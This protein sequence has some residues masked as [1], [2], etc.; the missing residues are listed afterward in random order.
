MKAFLKRFTFAFK[1][2]G[3]LFKE[4][5][6][7]RFHLLAAV[8]VVLLGLFFKLQSWEWAIIIM[9]IALVIGAEAMNSALENL[10]DKVSKEHSEL[11]GKAKDLAAASVLIFAISSLFIAAII[12]LP[13]IWMFIQ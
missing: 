6:N 1:G 3:I 2:L 13:K 5:A 8:V 7:A 12:F 9:Q 4:E 10:A 11:I